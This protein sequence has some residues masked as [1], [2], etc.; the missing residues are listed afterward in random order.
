MRV[1]QAYYWTDEWQSNE[2]AAVEETR[3]G[4]VQ[5]FDSADDAIRWLLAPSVFDEGAETPDRDH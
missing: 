3:I 5:R 4:N 1:D 2:A